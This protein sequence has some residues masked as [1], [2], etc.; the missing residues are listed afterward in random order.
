MVSPMLTYNYYPPNSFRIVVAIVVGFLFCWEAPSVPYMSCAMW[1]NDMV[2]VMVAQLARCLY[3][4]SRLYSSIHHLVY[5]FS[6]FACCFI[7]F[8]F[9]RM[10]C[11]T[12]IPYT[13]CETMPTV[14]N[15]AETPHKNNANEHERKKQQQPH[16]WYDVFLLVFFNG[17]IVW[18]GELNTTH[19][20]VFRMMEMQHSFGILTYT[21]I[22][23]NVMRFPI[24]PLNV[25]SANLRF[26]LVSPGCVSATGICALS[27]FH[28][29]TIS[30]S[31][32][33]T[34]FL[35]LFL[36]LFLTLSLSLSLFL[37]HSIRLSHSI[38]HP[39]CDLMLSAMFPPFK[40]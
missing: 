8:S 1:C 27:L 9:A 6:F 15:S 24:F 35:S 30:L 39:S 29:L 5:H 16:S 13:Q 25:W 3:Y 31:H 7:E 4:Y 23:S 26:N 38:A 14:A 11:T 37:P 34:L 40:F 12:Y 10:I 2:V 20:Y 18:Q 33:V 36:S 28:S 19:K 17:M 21:D 22:I 32:S